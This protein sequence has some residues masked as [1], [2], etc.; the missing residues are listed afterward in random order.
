MSILVQHTLADWQA[1]S[2]GDAAPD[3]HY[4]AMVLQAVSIM[5]LNP[6]LDDDQTGRR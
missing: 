4:Q 6:W 5:L 1:S 3:E 2:A